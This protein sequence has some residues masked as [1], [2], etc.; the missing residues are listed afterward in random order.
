M[1]NGAVKFSYLRTSY[2]LSCDYVC[3][4]LCLLDYCWHSNR[5]P[6]ICL[7][8]AV[9]GPKETFMN[10]PPGSVYDGGLFFLD[11]TFSSDYLFKASKVNFQPESNSVTSI[12]R[13]PSN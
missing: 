9:L 4:E 11:I 1:T 12:V 2:C 6:F 8:T 5:Q 13:E 3:N 10:G 7:L